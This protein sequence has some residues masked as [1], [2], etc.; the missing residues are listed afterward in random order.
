MYVFVIILAISLNVYFYFL[1]YIFIRKLYWGGCGS[2]AKIM[3]SSLDG[4]RSEVIVDED[5]KCISSLFID[6]SSNTLYWADINQHTIKE[7]N[8][9]KRTAPVLIYIVILINMN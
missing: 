8:L 7:L 2:S 5:I 4:S 3:S 1:F 9:A 6:Q